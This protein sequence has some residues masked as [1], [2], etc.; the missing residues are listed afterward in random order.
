MNE[1]LGNGQTGHA[2]E[3]YAAET[4][5]GSRASDCIACGQCEGACPQHL[6]IIDLL[7]QCAE[8]LE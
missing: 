8:T 5:E 4:A 7:A 1:H 3:M 2:R 6:P